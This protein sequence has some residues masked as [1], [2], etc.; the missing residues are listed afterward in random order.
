MGMKTK[1]PRLTE[2]DALNFVFAKA[3]GANCDCGVH[4]VA[5][6]QHSPECYISQNRQFKVVWNMLVK[7]AAKKQIKEYVA[8]RRAEN[9]G[10]PIEN[11]V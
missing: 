6:S 8:R 10:E 1:K 3:V 11:N 5:P 7:R 4:A 9:Y 2:F